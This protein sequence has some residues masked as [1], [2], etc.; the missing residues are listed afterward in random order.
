MKYSKKIKSRDIYSE[1][2]LQRF[3]IFGQISLGA[4][5]PAPGVGLFPAFVAEA[6]NSLFDLKSSVRPQTLAD[7]P[8]CSFSFSTHRNWKGKKSTDGITDAQRR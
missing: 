1:I 8:G 5:G 6:N 3:L 4:Q 2:L 7:H